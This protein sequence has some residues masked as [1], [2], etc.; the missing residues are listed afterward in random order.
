MQYKKTL[1]AVSDGLRNANGHLLMRGVAVSRLIFLFGEPLDPSISQK[2]I[3]HSPDGFNWGYSGSGCAQLALGVLLCALDADNNSHAEQ[4]AKELHQT[5]KATTIA[6][7]PSAN[8]EVLINFGRWYDLINK[9]TPEPANVYAQELMK[10]KASETFFS[11]FLHLPTAKYKTAEFSSTT[12]EFEALQQLTPM[13]FEE[14]QSWTKKNTKHKNVQRI[15][16][17]TSLTFN[18]VSNCYEVADGVGLNHFTG[19]PIV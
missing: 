17:T 14:L 11:M 6:L 16:V 7:L 3:N 9:S 8:F 13:Q 2:V 12:K 15:E 19:H 10:F 5:F 1:Q 4:R 18:E